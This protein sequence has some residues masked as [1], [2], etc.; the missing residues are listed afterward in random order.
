MTCRSTSSRISTTLRT[1]RFM[2]LLACTPVGHSIYLATVRYGLSKMAS[3][4]RRTW[5]WQLPLAR[6]RLEMKT[7]RMVRRL[8]ALSGL[9]V[10]G[11]GRNDETWRARIL[12]PDPRVRRSAVHDVASTVEPATAVPGLT[13]ALQDADEKV[14]VAA[15]LALLK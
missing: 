6:K 10:L 5:R 12:D 4:P 9:L 7:N 8:V 2:A 14:K 15:A 3:T 11:C 1:P 13:A